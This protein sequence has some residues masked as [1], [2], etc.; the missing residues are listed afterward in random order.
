MPFLVNSDLVVSAHYAMVICSIMCGWRSH[1]IE[2]ESLFKI[3][4]S[5]GV[6]QLGRLRDGVPSSVDGFNSVGFPTTGVHSMPTT[7]VHSSGYTG[8]AY[9]IAGVVDSEPLG[10][11]PPYSGLSRSEE[12][13]HKNAYCL[14]I[15]GVG[16]EFSLLLAP[17]HVSDVGKA[18]TAGT[19][20][21]VAA[22]TCV[23]D[24]LFS[25]AE[26]S[27]DGVCLGPL[28]GDKATQIQ[29]TFV[30]GTRPSPA[31]SSRQD[32]DLTVVMQ[33]TPYMVL[34]LPLTTVLVDTN[35]NCKV[36]LSQD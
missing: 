17:D 14:A 32:P 22:D 2:A 3:V 33:F 29:D 20:Y 31:I 6:F 12:G 28:K 19:M 7:S 21:A 4:Q 26:G 34:P 11:T 23:S 35:Q 36:L 16:K 24:G 25:C 15:G 10:S 30:D 9:C 18:T 8:F 13:D 1:G 5:A 27:K